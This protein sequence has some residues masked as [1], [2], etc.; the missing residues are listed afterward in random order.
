MQNWLKRKFERMLLCWE[1]EVTEMGKVA[2]ELMCLVNKVAGIDAFGNPDA[3]SIYIYLKEN[4][5][6]VNS[7]F[8][9]TGTNTNCC[10]I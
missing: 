10:Q 4:G 2:L 9:D 8:S 6:L 3:E 7:K 5:L 1:W